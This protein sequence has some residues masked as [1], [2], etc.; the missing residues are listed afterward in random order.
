MPLSASAVFLFHLF[1]IGKTFPFVDFYFLIWGNKQKKV[2]WGK[3]KYIGRVGHRGHTIFLSKTAE[4]SARY[5][6]VCSSI[7]HHEMVKCTESS[8]KFTEAE[9]ASHNNASWPTDTVWLLEHSPSGGSLYYK[10]PALQKILEDNSIVLQRSP[11]V[12]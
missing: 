10:E 6:Q 2:A 3:I 5:R 12:F 11:L 1:P 4:Q 8:K 9:A 7:T